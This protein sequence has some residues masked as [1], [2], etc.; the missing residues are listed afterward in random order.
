MATTETSPE[1][2]TIDTF[3]VASPCMGREIKAVVVLPP[4]YQEQHAKHYPVLYTFHGKAR[5]TTRSARWNRCARRCATS[6]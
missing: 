3:T 2:C 5:R 1:G 4:G 6:R